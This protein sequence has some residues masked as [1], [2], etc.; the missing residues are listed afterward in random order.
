[1]RKFL[2]ENVIFEMRKFFEMKITFEKE[3]SQLLK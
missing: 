1:M 2:N 3:K